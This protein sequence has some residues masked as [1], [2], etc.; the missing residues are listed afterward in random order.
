[1]PKARKVRNKEGGS[2]MK[3]WSIILLIGFLF[4]G[5]ALSVLAAGPDLT[6]V[7]TGGT[8]DVVGTSP[9]VQEEMKSPVFSEPLAAKLAAVVEH[10]RIVTNFLRRLIGG[11]CGFLILYTQLGFALLKTGSRARNAG[12][13]MAVNIVIC[14]IGM[15][16]YRIR[17]F[18]TRFLI[19]KREREVCYG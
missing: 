4:L 18:L 14:S 11:V 6:S 17:L 12:L 10:D 7:R 16:D 13:P 8:R 1:V 15:L 9:D 3:K 5:L 2:Q 19:P